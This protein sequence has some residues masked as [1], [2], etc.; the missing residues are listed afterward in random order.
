[1][2]FTTT[3][4][5]NLKHFGTEQ[6]KKIVNLCGVPI[7]YAIAAICSLYHNVPNKTNVIPKSTR[8][9]NIQIFPHKWIILFCLFSEFISPK[10]FF[11]S[12][13]ILPFSNQ[14]IPYIRRVQLNCKSFYIAIC[15]Q[16]R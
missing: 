5:N 15:D 7:K 14:C 13:A 11:F 8:T 2:I 3:P 6:K 16:D 9:N 4:I 12:L 10:S 1:M